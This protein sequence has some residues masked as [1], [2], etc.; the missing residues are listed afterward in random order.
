MPELIGE[1]R[2]KE[3]LRRWRKKLKTKGETGLLVDERGLAKGYSM[4][5]PKTKSVTDADKIKRLKIEVAYLKAKNDF[6]VKL[7]AQKKS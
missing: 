7:R 2:A 6:L 1:Y 3:C 5:R 4:G